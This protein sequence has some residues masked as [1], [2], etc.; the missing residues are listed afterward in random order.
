MLHVPAQDDDLWCYVYRLKVMI[1]DVTCAVQSSVVWCLLRNNL[2]CEMYII[3]CKYYPGQKN[4][5]S[6]DIHEID[7]QCDHV[8]SCD[9]DFDL[10]RDLRRAD[11]TAGRVDGRTEAQYRTISHDRTVDQPHEFFSCNNFFGQGSICDVTWTGLVWSSV[12]WPVC[13]AVIFGVTFFGAIISDV[14]ISLSICVTVVDSI[15]FFLFLLCQAVVKA[16]E[17]L[18]Q[19]GKVREKV[20]GK[21]K[22]YMVVQVGGSSIPLVKPRLGEWG[23]GGG[24]LCKISVEPMANSCPKKALA[25]WVGVL[26]SGM[27]RPKKPKLTLLYR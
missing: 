26:F 11:S 25:H 22:V 5:N 16:L 13:G 12:M 23:G 27:R 20:Y 24:G 19:Q 9:I 18:S 15:F 6:R 2:W 14:N 4:R 10:S 3:L 21:Q 8:I 7:P 1:C 17:E